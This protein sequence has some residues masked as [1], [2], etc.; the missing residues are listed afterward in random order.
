MIRPTPHMPAHASPR[1][2]T[3]DNTVELLRRARAGERDALERL[4]HHH[5][6]ILRH[7][8]SRRLPRWARDAADT[9]DIVQETIIQTLKRLDS[10]EPRG[11]GALQAYLRQA[12]MN[13][14]R[15]AIRSASSRPPAS[16]LPWDLP[17]DG[18]SPL[19]CAISQQAL[20]RYEAGLECLTALE[21]DAVVGR[22]ELGL[23]Y[24]EL[25][26]HLGKSSPDA[27]R[28]TVGRALLKLAQAMDQ[29]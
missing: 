15:N 7:W 14:I 23:S 9:S 27:A 10:F 29:S 24:A 21:R 18:M 2:K 20:Q 17:D 5:L 8:A 6:P 28:M 1:R 16:E 11:D 25:A 12:V 22:I 26:E 19:E 13:R 4:L 3:D